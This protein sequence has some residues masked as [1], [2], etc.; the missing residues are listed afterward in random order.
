MGT[1]KRFGL[2]ADGFQRDLSLALGS[3]SVTP[4]DIANAYS[5]FANGGYRVTPGPFSALKMRMATSSGRQRTSFSASPLP[6]TSETG[7]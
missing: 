3:A 2:P 7:R 5:V 4:M 6:A 1:L